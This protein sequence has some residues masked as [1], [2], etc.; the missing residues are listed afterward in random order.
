MK[1]L[2]LCI[3]GVIGGVAGCYL[4]STAD[5]LSA[6]A[7]LLLL[8]ELW[9]ACYL[10]MIL[11]EA[12]HLVFGRLNGYTLT[13]F[14]IGKCMLIRREGKWTVR[15]YHIP[16]TGGQCLMCPPEG[17][18]YPVLLY[19]LGGGLMNLILAGLAV[20]LVRLVPMPAPVRTFFVFFALCGVL[21]GLTNLLPMRAGGLD[22]DG[23]NALTLGKNPVNRWALA[24]QLRVNAAQAQGK[25]LAE[26][27]EDWFAPLRTADWNDPLTGAV[28]CIYAGRKME[29]GDFAGAKEDLDRLLDCPKLNAVHRYECVLEQRCCR[30]MLGEPCSEPLEKAVEKFRKSTRRYFISRLR[31]E[32]VQALLEDK[33][34]ARAGEIREEFERR[35]ARAPYPGEAAGEAGLLDRARELFPKSSESGA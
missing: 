29:G 24:V 8:A 22:N 13:S 17:E 4:A 27:P 32:Y 2:I 5:S 23:R 33:N 12:G 9:I 28:A 34:P 21:F 31:Q 14:R 3:A 11:H 19:N 25:T 1:L 10:Q 20:L 15:R 16:G 26:L 18:N 7:I 35:A 30:A 6:G